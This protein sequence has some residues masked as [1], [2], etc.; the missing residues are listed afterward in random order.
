MSGNASAGWNQSL[1]VGFLRGNQTSIR[2]YWNTTGTYLVALKTYTDTGLIEE[3]QEPSNPA[4]PGS[5]TVVYS[6]SGDYDG[7]YV[8]SVTD[9]MGHAMNFVYDRGTGELSSATDANGNTTTYT[10]TD[11][12]ERLTNVSHA[13]GSHN[14]PATTSYSYSA[15]SLTAEMMLD[16]TKPMES[17]TSTYDGFGRTVQVLHSDPE[18]DVFSDNHYNATGYISITSTPYRS[19]NDGIFYEE[20]QDTFDGLGRLIHSQHSSD[21]STQDIAYQG[22]GVASALASAMQSSFG[23]L[24]TM[25]SDSNTVNLVSNAT[26]SNVNWSVTTST[27]YDH[28]HFSQDS[29]LPET[30]G[31]SGGADAVTGSPTPIYSY[32]TQHAL[33]GQITQSS[34]TINGTWSYTF[35]EFNRLRTASAVRCR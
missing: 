7:A 19:K 6:R 35:D 34:N 22:A 16:N 33:N 5:G 15:N 20:V 18:G 13:G 29:F 3:V 4:I 1:P 24:L 12:M 27:T 31:M 28:M 14:L 17:T 32:S 25:T 11:P 10:Y 26:G 8:T 23:C 9:A 30:F 21:S 2:R